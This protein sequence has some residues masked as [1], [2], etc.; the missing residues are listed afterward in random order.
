MRERTSHALA[1]VVTLF[2][3]GGFAL[4]MVA[5]LGIGLGNVWRGWVSSGWPTAEAVV[6]RVEMTSHTSRDSRRQSST[7]T[8][9]ADLT[10]RYTVNGVERATD[11]VRWGQTLGSGDPAEA[12][13]L[14]LRYPEGRRVTVRYD[15]AQPN[16]AVV[17]PGLT[18]SALLL[19][20][21]AIAFL[22]FLGPG[23]VMV[24]RMFLVSGGTGGRPGHPRFG[25]VIA[26]FLGFPIL[27]GTAMTW[28]GSW[29][30]L[31]ASRSRAWPSTTAAWLQ[32]LP[33]DRVPGVEAV[34]EHRGFPYVYRYEV[35][36]V[37]RYQCVRW[38]GQGTARGNDSDA[39]IEREFP[40]GQPLTVHYDPADPDLAVLSPGIRRFAWIL[41]GGGVGFVVFGWIGILAM[42][43]RQDGVPASG[44]QRATPRHR[45][46]AGRTRAR[47]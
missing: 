29:N 16:E 26:V 24:W 31:L 5:L 39:E 9:R 23:C 21:A 17:V 2:V 4:G 35:E 45:E 10:F 38:F 27:M 46:R 37:P 25:S 28:A 41:P 18:A 22:L 36:G 42:R 14:A 19:P 43:R 11:Q 32:D 20:G 33:A 44:S 1:G 40:R 30:L 6:A 15:P 7:T 12:V 34:R 47:Y 3:L 8:Y 13:V